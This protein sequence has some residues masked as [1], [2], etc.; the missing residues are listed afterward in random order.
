MREIPDDIARLEGEYAEIE[1]KLEAVAKI[2]GA[3]FSSAV[4]EKRVARPSYK[5]RAS[6]TGKPTWAIEILRV[7]K[8]A[9]KPL[10]YDEL[11]D[12]IDKGPLQGDFERSTKGFYN[13][14]SRLQKKSEVVKHSDRLFLA[15]DFRAFER[16]LASGN[17][18][19]LP[20]L[21]THI[22]RSPMGAEV[23]ALVNKHPQGVQGKDVIE[24]L[25]ADERFAEPLL[26][27]TSGGYNVIARLV[28]RN[29]IRRVDSTLY[30]FNENG[31]PAG[32][33]EAESNEVSGLFN[34]Q[35]SNQ[36]RSS[37]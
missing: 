29:E 21:R 26:K 17:A 20:P 37:Q 2:L 31:E 33:P 3:N 25:R 35:M 7:L 36:G 30:P 18:K 10:S 32:S 27:N 4:S 24:H 16:N 13:A 19:P 6:S 14:V 9:G 1:E 28:E 8:S 5:P 34:S 23:L 11:R 22:D 12:E 15:H